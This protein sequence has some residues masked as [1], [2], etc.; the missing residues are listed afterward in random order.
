MQTDDINVPCN[1]GGFERESLYSYIGDEKEGYRVVAKKSASSNNFGVIKADGKP[2]IEC[3]Y[4]YIRDVVNG[5][6]VFAIGGTGYNVEE[7]ELEK[8]RDPGRKN[9]QF[10][11]LDWAKWGIIDINGNVLFEPFADFMQVI[12]EGKVTYRIKDKYGVLDLSTGA[13]RLTEYDYLSSFYEGR[14]VAG[15]IRKLYDSGYWHLGPSSISF[16]FIKDDYS[17]LIPC[18]YDSASQYLDE[19]VLEVYK[20]RDMARITFDLDG[21][22]IDCTYEH[23]SDPCENID[24]E[25]ETWNALT[26]GQYG[27][28]PGPG[29]DFDLLD[30][31]LGH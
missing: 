28:Y 8:L 16:G 3:K 15:K 2:V 1:N 13:K 19:G 26:D 11:R 12:S 23:D 18:E 10:F 29:V 24:W 25:R 27:D 5:M 21:K 30:D 31:S 22:V 17:E 9:N 20:D 4:S 14:C 6:F 7:C